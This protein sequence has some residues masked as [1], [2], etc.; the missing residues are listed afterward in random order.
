MN[1]GPASPGEVDVRDLLDPE[2]APFLAGFKLPPLE[3]DTLASL[4]GSLE[5]PGLSDAVVRTEHLVPGD[6]PV[7]V[8]VH[9]S[10]GAEGPQPAIV[11]I[12]GGGYV[13]G[14]YDLDD[15]LLD[16]WCPTLGVVG[17][18][19]QYRLAPEHPYPGPL[20]DC[21][22]ALRWT[23]DKADMLGVD[24]A[25][26]GV[27]GV[28]AGGGLAA[29]LA[30]LARDRLEHPLAFQLLDCPM[31]DDRQATPSMCADGLYVWDAQSNEFGWRSYLG[32]LYGSDVPPYAAAARATDLAGLPPT[33]VVVGSIDGFRDEDM[34]YAQRLNQ[35][36]VPCE[37]HVIARMPHAYQMAPGATSVRLAQHCMDDWL[38]RQL[39]RSNAGRRRTTRPAVDALLRPIAKWAR[40]SGLAAR[41]RRL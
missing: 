39:N 12:H 36:G 22:A 10:K 34:E 15:Q 21:Y 24:R 6:P 35:A 3:T 37:L 13:I 2:L 20:E 16:A 7:S 9:R 32:D 33:C 31:I 29:A 8:R 40:R 23:H 41:L 18:S 11:T 5:M 28:S 17:V 19:V 38:A 1:D 14:S 25:R 27:Y 4:R 30:L 26:I